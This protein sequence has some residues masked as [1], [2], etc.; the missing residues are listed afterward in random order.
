MSCGVGK[1]AP[2]SHGLPLATE[3]QPSYGLL[4]VFADE[5]AIGSED[6][7]YIFM[8]KLASHDQGLAPAVGRVEV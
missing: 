2:N 4:E 5:L 3:A 7:L 8:P 6:Y 1:F